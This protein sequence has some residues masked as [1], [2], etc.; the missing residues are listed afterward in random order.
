MCASVFATY[1]KAHIRLPS[2]A[3]TS[4]PLPCLLQ[5]SRV[6]VAYSRAS[7]VVPV[8]VTLIPMS[9]TL[10]STPRLAH[11]ILGRVR[12]HRTL[13]AANL[14]QPAVI[15]FLSTVLHD[16]GQPVYLVVE[17]NSWHMAG[18]V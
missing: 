15:T 18:T 3:Q 12:A 17:I 7:S 2:D 4:L 5:D 13:V 1:T 14:L 9:V 10:R 6:E 8:A 16:S 11:V